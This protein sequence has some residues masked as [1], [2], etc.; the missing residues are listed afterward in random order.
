M[1]ETLKYRAALAAVDEVTNGMVVGLGTG[2]TVKHFIE[3][4]G[5]RVRAGLKIT[6]IATSNQSDRLAREV[7]IP[8]VGFEQQ[9]FL[10]VTVDGADEV[11]P[12]LDLIK[13]LGGAMVREKIVAKASRRVVIIVDDSKLVDQLCTHTPI[14]VEVIPLAATLV[15]DALRAIGGE[16]KLRLRAG[17]PFVS[18]NGNLVVDWQCGTISEPSFL[19]HRLKSMSGVV[20]SGIFSGLAH[21]VIVAGAQGLRE[22]VRAV[23]SAD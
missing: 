16:S 21:R 9:Q 4:L 22:M 3:E 8:I 11:S 14:P 18:D 5:I 20:D 15:A 12:E 2:S 1:T 17:E 7:G 19:E 10:D 6:A 23:D 13:G